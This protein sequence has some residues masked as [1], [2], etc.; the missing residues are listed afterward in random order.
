[1]ATEI[2]FK[3]V[4]KAF[5]V[6]EC[7]FL[8]ERSATVE[9]QRVVLTKLLYI[10]NTEGLAGFSAKECGELFFNLTKILHAP[11]T[12]L[13][14]LAVQCLER[15]AGRVDS[16]FFLTG[17]L[18]KLFE[19]SAPLKPTCLRLLGAVSGPASLADTAK[20]V[21]M[22]AS[23]PRDER[24]VASACFAAARAGVSLREQAASNVARVAGVCGYALAGFVPLERLA[25][26]AGECGPYA[27]LCLV[28]RLAADRTT[29]PRRVLGTLLALLPEAPSGKRA[30][31]SAA[32]SRSTSYAAHMVPLAALRAL[33]TLP[34]AALRP[35]AAAVAAGYAAFLAATVSAVSKVAALRTASEFLRICAGAGVGAGGGSGAP[36]GAAYA[37]LLAALEAEAGSASPQAAALACS[38][39]LC[40]GSALP[41]GLSARLYELLPELRGRVRA[42]AVLTLTAYTQ[43]HAEESA[44]LVDLLA[45][46]LAGRDA[47]VA[48]ASFAALAAICRCGDGAAA[49]AALAAV[50]QNLEDC[51]DE[52]IAR[53]SCALVAEGVVRAAA[54]GAPRDAPQDALPHAAPALRALWNRCNLDCTAVQLSAVRALARV[55]TAAAVPDAVRAE[56]VRIL[57]TVRALAGG[58][59][60]FVGEAASAALA[61]AGRH[62]QAGGGSDGRAQEQEPWQETR[63]FDPDSVLAHAQDLLRGCA[64]GVGLLDGPVGRVPLHQSGLGG[65]GAGASTSTSAGAGAGASTRAGERAGDA[66][67]SGSAAGLY[68]AAAC[69]R[70]AHPEDALPVGDAWTPTD[71]GLQA[72]RYRDAFSSAV[73]DVLTSAAMDVV[74]TASRVFYTAKKTA[75]V[76]LVFHLRTLD[77]DLALT[78][79]RV[80][81]AAAAGPLEAAFPDTA[82]GREAVAFVD[83]AAGSLLAGADSAAALARGA[84][85]LPA[86]LRFAVDGDADELALLPVAFSA[87]DLVTRFSRTPL[88]ADALR[89]GAAP[90]VCAL[91]HLPDVPA[92][93][94]AVDRLPGFL[95][96]AFAGLDSASAERCVFFVQ[97]AVHLH[98]PI[99]GR[100]TVE[101]AAEG[102]QVRLELHGTKDAGEAVLRILDGPQ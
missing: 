28:H 34:A 7:R 25:A 77:A 47:D 61:E 74:V 6:Q 81:L 80:V 64:D 33:N 83:A 65:R 102:V 29:D 84:A 16:A 101:R 55:C 2:D 99:A 68:Y 97:G 22:C 78:G 75:R 93:D 53:Q 23:D 24:L 44:G 95:G 60:T 31:A 90:A 56:G 66:A 8:G 21:K 45:P 76:L 70:E 100:V 58:D 50:T 57:S 91:Y 59:D 85:S 13:H 79:C 32:S 37:P 20:L 39:L 9:S 86:R 89:G 11:S 87:R 43:Q 35:H 14:A 1:M 10:L 38:A 18:L 15:V 42:E 67:G 62:R 26:Q 12:A 88:D 4:E 96:L 98:G 72:G 46:Q 49:R 30:Y 92:P 52:S 3:A 63:H 41:R 51:A 71:G 54:A 40:Y 36:L 5:V 82:G 17:S 73:A 69:L 19:S 27:T 48:Q 94:E